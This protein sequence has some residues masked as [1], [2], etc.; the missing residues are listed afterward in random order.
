MRGAIQT[1]KPGRQ[2]PQVWAPGP[3]V[4]F[5]L[6]PDALIRAGGPKEGERGREGMRPRN[7]AAAEQGGSLTKALAFKGLERDEYN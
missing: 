7:K 4:D 5:R 3:A 6:L 2:D 1:A